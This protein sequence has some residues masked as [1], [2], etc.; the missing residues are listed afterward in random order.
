M[1]PFLCFSD[2]V[3]LPKFR[4]SS[5][6]PTVSLQ[7]SSMTFTIFYFYFTT[8]LAR[9]LRMFRHT[10]HFFFYGQKGN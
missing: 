6:M 4:S 7:K 5:F 9:I 8:T 2:K 1:H 10:H 3:M